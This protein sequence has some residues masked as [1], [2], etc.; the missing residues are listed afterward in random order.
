MHEQNTPSLERVGRHSGAGGQGE[1][2]AVGAQERALRALAG[3]SHPR[4]AVEAVECLRASLWQNMIAALREPSTADVAGLADRVA[5]LCSTLLSA[6][7]GGPAGALVDGPES[8]RAGDLEL[9][10]ATSSLRS[11]TRRAPAPAREGLG[12]SRHRRRELTR[13]RSRRR[14]RV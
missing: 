5:Q 14:R 13:R 3:A 6:S 4:D 9:P 1:P 11:G 8:A 12:G 7:L 10:S 2:A